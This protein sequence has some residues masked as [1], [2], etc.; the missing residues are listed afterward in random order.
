MTTLPSLPRMAVFAVAAAL[1]LAAGCGGDDDGGAPVIQP[2]TESDSIS[3][4]DGTDTGG[5]TGGQFGS[6]TFTIDG[7]TFQWQ[8][9]CGAVRVVDGVT[10]P[11]A[12][13]QSAGLELSTGAFMSFSMESGEGAWAFDISNGETGERWT[14]AT[15]AVSESNNQYLVTG[16]AFSTSNPEPRPFELSVSCP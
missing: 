4:D 12:I 6:A 5:D 10:Q 9:S 1:Q 13:I 11:G 14:L 7:T 15:P 2:P 16:D 3:A 8:S